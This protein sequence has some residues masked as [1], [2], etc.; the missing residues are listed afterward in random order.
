MKF[1]N[2]LQGPV[3]NPRTLNLIQ[4]TLQGFALILI[5]LSSY[6]QVASLSI[7]LGI[8]LWY[9]IPDALKTKVQVRIFLLRNISNQ[10]LKE[11]FT[12][13]YVFIYTNNTISFR[14]NTTRDFSSLKLDYFRKQNTWINQE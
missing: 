5:Y 9:M 4:W 11:L 13:S 1:L 3:E 14:L 10:H 8:L 6:H 12:S 2:I 7:A